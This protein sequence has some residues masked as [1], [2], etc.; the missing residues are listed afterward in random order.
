[1][2]VDGV[3]NGQLIHCSDGI[4]SIKNVNLGKTT[5]DSC[6]DIKVDYN[7]GTKMC[8]NTVCTRDINCYEDKTKFFKSSCDYKKIC[9]IIVDLDEPCGGTYKYLDLAWECLNSNQLFFYTLICEKERHSGRSID[10]PSGLISIKNVNWGRTN[11]ETCCEIIGDE[12]CTN[13]INCYLDK[14]EFFKSS[15][16]NKK[17][18]PISVDLEDPCGGTYK[19]LDISWECLNES[20]FFERHL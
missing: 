5:S 15:C 1:M 16:D 6:C 10:C 19:Y 18:C 4:I 2:C 20:K 13:N 11:S 17:T 9:S 8:T 3:N 7:G 12:I 14:T